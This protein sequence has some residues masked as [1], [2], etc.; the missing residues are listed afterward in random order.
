MHDLPDTD[1]ADASAEKF[2]PEGYKDVLRMDLKQAFVTMVL[3]CEAFRSFYE[4]SYTERFGDYESFVDRLAEMIVIGAE[5]GVDLVLGEV[6]DAFRNNSPFPDKRYYA[7]YFWPEVFTEN[8]KKGL[9]S[10][11]FEEF[12]NHHAYVHIYEDHYESDLSFDEFIAQIADL[13]VMGAANGADDA[14]GDIYRAFLDRAPL[15]TARRRP[16]RLR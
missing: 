15:P 3:A 11:A 6:Y 13:V 9:A 10:K 8:L 7:M 12:D 5:N 14:L 4:S 16:R 2:W 1:D